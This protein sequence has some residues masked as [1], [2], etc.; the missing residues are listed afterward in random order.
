[1]VAARS[2]N[3]SLLLAFLFF[4]SASSEGIL[5]FCF[6]WG[7]HDLNDYLVTT[8]LLGT[9]LP[10]IEKEIVMHKHHDHFTNHKSL[11]LFI[12]VKQ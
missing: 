6:G 11:I 4:S 12:E 9:Y 8:T 5:V 3:A 10:G 1:M 2:L 7:H